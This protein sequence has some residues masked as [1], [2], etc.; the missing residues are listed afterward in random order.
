MRKMI[1]SVLVVFK[2]MAPVREKATKRKEF[3]M[4]IRSISIHTTQ[5]VTPLKSSKRQPQTAPQDQCKTK[6]LKPGSGQ[7]KK[8]H[9]LLLSV[10]DLAQLFSVACAI[11]I[12]SA[13]DSS[14]GTMVEA[15]SASHHPRHSNHTCRLLRHWQTL[16]LDLIKAVFCRQY[17]SNADSDVSDWIEVS[18]CAGIGGLCCALSSD[19]DRKQCPRH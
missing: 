12:T 17:L 18:R 1:R 3:A 15:D 2:A 8:T 10:C 5:N 9:M 19:T 16:M 11:E 7:L 4:N 14:F 6:Q 13:K